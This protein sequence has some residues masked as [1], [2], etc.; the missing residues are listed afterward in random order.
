MLQTITFCVAKLIA[1]L[2]MNYDSLLSQFQKDGYLIIDDF[3]DRDLMR[4]LH[5][6]IL[7]H[8]GDDPAFL[9]TDEFLKKAKPM[10]FHGFRRVRCARNSIVLMMMKGCS[11]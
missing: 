7:D 10:L 9:H 6:R 11:N 2:I 5:T 8:F 4:R 1:S 3:F